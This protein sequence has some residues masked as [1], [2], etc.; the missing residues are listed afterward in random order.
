MCIRDSG[1]LDLPVET[2]TVSIE[3]PSRDAALNQRI[4]DNVRRSLG[5]FPGDAFQ[6]D[7]AAFVISRMRRNPSIGDI[8]YSYALGASGGLEVIFNVKLREAATAASGRGYLLTKNSSD[9][10]VLYDKDGTYLRVKADALSLYYANNNAWYGN[11]SAMLAGNPLVKGKP[12][13][14]GYDLS[15]IHISEPTRPY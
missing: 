4:E 5:L 2:V 3:N 9:L 1:Y 8:T 15:L 12:A 10:P 11:P 6:E 7:H 13:G 14:A